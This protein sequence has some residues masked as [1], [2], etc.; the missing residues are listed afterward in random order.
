MENFEVVKLRFFDIKAG[1]LKEVQFI[2]ST[3]TAKRLAQA[4]LASPHFAEVSLIAEVETRITVE[5]VCD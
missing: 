4:I 5:D 2:N 1:R 3:D